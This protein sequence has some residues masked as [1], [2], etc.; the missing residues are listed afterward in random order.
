[1]SNATEKEKD[2]EKPEKKRLS[3]AGWASNKVSSITGRGKKEKESIMKDQDDMNSDS[4][5]SEDMDRRRSVPSSSR[6]SP[7]KNRPS[8]NGT[9]TAS[10]IIPPRPLKLPSQGGKKIA[11][12]LHDFSAGSSDELTF[13]TGDHIVVLNEVL[14]GWWMG[15]LGGKKGLFPTTYTE[16]VNS[17]TSSLVSKPPLPRRPSMGLQLPVQPSR[18]SPSPQSSIEEIKS[19]STPRWLD[20]QITG[21]LSIA[22][23]DDHP[24]GDNF[25]ASSRSPL[26]GAFYAESIVDSGDEYEQEDRQNERLVPAQSDSDNDGD[27]RRD[28]KLPSPTGPPPVPTRRLSIPGPKK[29]PPP[30]P[31]RR[32]NTSNASSLNVPNI[33]QRAGVSPSNSSSQSNSTNTSFVSVPAASALPHLDDGGLTNSPFDSPKDT[34]GCDAFKQNPFKPRGMCSNCFQMHHA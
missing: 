34:S 33:P 23:E 8:A 9:P 12:A 19:K 5:D 13:K 16:V 31:P 28:G 11:I 4:D 15:E 25:I 27:V 26:N 20:H 14:D 2:K 29:P 22:S 18:S 17:S 6:A 10:P 21:E 32:T 30:P 7:T 24:F 1:M 3:V